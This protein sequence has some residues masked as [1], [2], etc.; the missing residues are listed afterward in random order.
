MPSRNEVGSFG[1]DMFDQM[2]TDWERA[3]ETSRQLQQDFFKHWTQPWLS[4]TSNGGVVGEGLA[5]QKRW[6]EFAIEALNRQRESIDTT[7]QSAVR[8]LEATVRA[9]QV[10]SPEEYRRIFE[11]C[12]SQMME[13]FRKQSE[14]QMRSFRNWTEKTLEIAKQTTV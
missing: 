9:A 13:N 7:Y 6:M 4:T 14:V 1:G 3:A 2:F 5:L 11:E 12:W 8:L 10:T